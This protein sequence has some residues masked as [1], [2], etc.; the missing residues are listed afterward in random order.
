MVMEEEKYNV[1]ILAA[2][3]VDSSGEPNF[4]QK[5]FQSFLHRMEIRPLL[6][7]LCQSEGKNKTMPS[8][9]FSPK[10]DEEYKG[11][12]ENCS[13]SS[14]FWNEK[15]TLELFEGQQVQTQPGSLNPI[16]TGHFWTLPSG[17]GTGEPDPRAILSDLWHLLEGSLQVHISNIFL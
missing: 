16:F 7:L 10:V 17:S 9:L 11:K 2:D 14:M 12:T 4:P 15:F 6:C 3:S 13:C 1:N 8:F 5:G